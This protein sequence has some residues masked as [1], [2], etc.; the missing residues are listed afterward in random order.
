[1]SIVIS[2]RTILSA[3]LA[4]TALACPAIGQ[5]RFPDRPVRFLIP[6]AP[7]GTLDGFM[8]LQAELFQQ[9]TG[10]PLIIENRAGAR[11]TLAAQALLTQARPDGYTIAHHHLSVIRHPFLTKRP[12]WDPVNDFTYIMQQTGFVFGHVVHPASGWNSLADLWAAARKRP[13]ELT[14]GTSGIATS[15]HLAMEELCEKEGV[16]MVHVP[17]RGTAENITSLLARQIDCIA[18]SNSWQPNVEAGQMKLLAVWTRERLKSFPEVPTLLDLGYGMSVTSPYGI[19]GPKGMDPAIVERL[20][21][22]F[23]GTQSHPRVQEFM[24][25]NDLPN[26]YLGPRDYTAFAVERA[27]YEQRMVAHLNLSID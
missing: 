11:G 25:R 17:F 2:R 15:N 1:M 24:N 7:G 26:E 6:W 12:S 23:R 10:Q 21:Q 20:H 5:T 18:N 19:A 14:Y 9:E 22:L 16:K 27:Q 13:G 4:T 3:T 8:R